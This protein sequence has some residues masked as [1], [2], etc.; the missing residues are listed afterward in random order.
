MRILGAP[1]WQYA[2][3]VAAAVSQVMCVLQWGTAATGTAV[4]LAICAVAII[5]KVR[6][7]GESR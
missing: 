5:S 7:N 1:G 3:M 6:D 4:N 2:Y